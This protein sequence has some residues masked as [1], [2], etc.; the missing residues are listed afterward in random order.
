MAHRPALRPRPQTGPQAELELEAQRFPCANSDDVVFAPDAVAS[1]TVLA[2][3][4]QT[5]RWVGR[6]LTAQSD[7]PARVPGVIAS[8]R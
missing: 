7:H 3:K 6:S 4:L 1:M 8:R 2:S 5:V